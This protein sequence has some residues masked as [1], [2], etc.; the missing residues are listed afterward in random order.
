VA[1]PLFPYLS[2][3]PG[4]NKRLRALASQLK[5]LIRSLDTDLWREHLWLAG[6]A[7]Y[8]YCPSRPRR[9]WGPRLH[10]IAT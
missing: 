10:L 8:G 6:W 7:G 4:Y 5:Q 9:F 2:K 3:Q 1:G